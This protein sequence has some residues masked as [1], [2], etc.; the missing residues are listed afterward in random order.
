MSVLSAAVNIL[1]LCFTH[2]DEDEEDGTPG[3]LLA[4]VP[5]R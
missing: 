1:I 2:P 5:S 3:A 4:C